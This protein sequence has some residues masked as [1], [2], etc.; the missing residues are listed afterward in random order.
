MHSLPADGVP[1]FSVAR[2]VVDLAGVVR[3][4]AAACRPAMDA[5]L[6]SFALQLPDAEVPV[7]GE[8]GRLEQI[9]RN[10]LD[11]A[12]K[13]TPDHGHIG[14]TLGVQAGDAVLTVTDDGIGITVLAL[15]DIFEP[16]AQDLQA[17]GC[18]GVGLGI[19]LTVVRTLAEAHGGS[20]HAQSA[21]TGCGSTFTVSLP[22]HQAAG[23]P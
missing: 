5:R 1:A 11:N 4:A 7:L 8:P 9:V 15:P 3:A 22:L 13:H 20:V 6:Q 17:I 12:S 23:P 14:L 10:L 19:G 18:N 21:G 16:F 2:D